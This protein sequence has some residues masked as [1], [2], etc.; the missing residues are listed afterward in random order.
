MSI[1][2][3][4][5]KL[6]IGCMFAGKTA[7]MANDVERYNISGKSCLIIKYDKDNRYNN[8]SKNGGIVC[9]DGLERSKIP[10]WPTSS[11][12]LMNDVVKQFDVI[13]ISE[14]QFFKDLLIVDDWANEG[15]IIICDGLDGDFKRESFGMID[16]LIPKCEKVIKLNA[17]CVECK[18]KSAAFTKK[19][20]GDLNTIE[21]IGGI[22]T[23]LPVCRGCYN[24]D[25]KK[26]DRFTVEEF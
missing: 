24:K 7:S 18:S 13:G 1:G 19:I 25:L 2:A 21:Q 9:N 8:L 11:L 16:K 20:D 5:I 26:D 4:K 12:T 10:S 17:V 22:E 15:K 6:Y 3:G 14:S 23:Y